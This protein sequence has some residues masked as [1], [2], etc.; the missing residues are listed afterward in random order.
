MPVFSVA[1]RRNRTLKM[2]KDNGQVFVVEL[3]RLLDVSEVTIRKDLQYLERRNLLIRTHGGAML[4]D[5]LVQ[6]QHFDEKGKR[7]AAEKQRIGEAAAGLVEDGDTILMDAGTTMIQIA[8]HLN[9]KRKLTILTSAINVAME[10]L[11]LPDIQLVMLGGLIR[12]TSAAVVG[13]YAE[14]MVSDHYCSKFFLAVDGLD[15]DFGLTTTN[16]ME[17]HLNK[18]MIESA[19]KTILV[20]DSSKFGRRGLSRICGLDRIHMV[21]TD[22]GISDAM[23]R[24][25]EDRGVEL[26]VV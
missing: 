24:V 12:S 1:E 17:A 10:L 8:R 6:D 18:M 23:R 4:N 2:L 11:R 19:R 26:M 13:P 22:G 7:Y 25:L 3:S 14:T 5:Y 21:I 20:M 15:P 16:A 9:G